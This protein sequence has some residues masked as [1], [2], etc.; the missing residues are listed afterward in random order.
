MVSGRGGSYPAG[1]TSP[2]S[3]A[4]LRMTLAEYLRREETSEGKHE[5]H[6]GE[7][8]AMS[9][10]AYDH[11]AIATNLTRTLG[12]RLQGRPCEALDSNMR[13]ATS[14][15]RRFVYPD[16][17][18]LCGPPEFHPEDRKKTTLVNPRV[19]FEVLSEST[20]DYDRGEKFDHYRRIPSLEEYV[21]VVQHQPMVQGF[22]RQ[23][24]GTW[25][26]ATWEGPAAVG[27][28][29]CVGIDLPLAELYAG[30]EFPER[31]ARPSL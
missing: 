30:V 23:A 13:V 6:D 5:F 8:L 25:S 29:R 27:R 20:S 7:V 16:A 26:M 15:T 17:S 4:A 21:L 12:N 2:A 11:A 18:I 10:G 24:D 14:V 31:P 22:L 3:E 28:V 9:G 19:I 1:M